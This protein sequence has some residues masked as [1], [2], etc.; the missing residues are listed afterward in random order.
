MSWDGVSDTTCPIA[1]GLSI[2]GERWTLL[3]MRELG[4]GSRRFD[5]IQAQTGMSSHLLSLR[6]KQ[7]EADGVI[8]R[9]LPEGGSKRF[10]Y[11]A[12]QKGQELDRVLLAVRAWGLKWGE[13]GPDEEPATKLVYKETGKPVRD[14]FMT[15]GDSD[16]E[17]FAKTEVVM[18]EAFSQ[19]RQRKLTSFKEAKSIKNAAAHA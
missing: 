10:E 11:Y 18:S 7:L 6:L 8:E 5:D 13:Y 17:R 12:T 3:I 15:F 19:E 14:N 9:R 16:L 1:R 4:M 2:V